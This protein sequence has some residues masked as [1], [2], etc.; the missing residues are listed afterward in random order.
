M[1]QEPHPTGV[2]VVVVVVRIDQPAARADGGA[3][4]SHGDV[5]SRSPPTCGGT[6]DN[7]PGGVNVV[8]VNGGDTTTVQETAANDGTGSESLCIVCNEPLVWV[9]VGRCGHRAVCRRCTVRLRFFHR[10][11]R[12]RV[13]R[14][15]C[16]TVVVAKTSASADILST[17]PLFSLR[18]G[19]VGR[20]WYHRLTAAYY[21][22][23][24]EYQA[25]RA[26]CQGILSPFFQPWVARRR[27]RMKK[28]AASA[29]R[30]A[31]GGI[32]S[33]AARV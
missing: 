27:Q 14:T 11:K 30:N 19:R 32:R 2:Q 5:E 8:V 4:T 17:L 3:E 20:L 1:E 9:A 29:K 33:A 23:E 12:C 10:D 18:E 26:A 15:R 6:A 22:D 31:V 13:C 28:L 7:V 16:P 25:A 24:H 21:E